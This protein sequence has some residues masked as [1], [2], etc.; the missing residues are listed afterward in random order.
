MMAFLGP[1]GIN[2]RMSEI[3][4]KLDAAFPQETAAAFQRELGACG[5]NVPMDPF[6]PTSLSGPIGGAPE[7]RSMADEAA[8]RYGVDKNL[9]A[10]LVDAESDWNPSATSPVGAKGLCQLMD[11]TARDLGVKDSYDPAQS[12]DGG[13]KYLR[14]MLDKFGSP[15]KALAAY[16]AGPGF[17]ERHNAAQWPHETRSY[18]SR[19][20]SRYG[21]R[22]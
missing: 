13:A 11:P 21:S 4:A 12:L 15:D 20:L 17:V 6:N 1:E 18:V 5:A 14:Q 7:L 3:Q 16:N 10:A 19:I 2:R 9:F 8:A 22:V